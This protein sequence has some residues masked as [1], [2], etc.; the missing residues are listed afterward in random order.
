MAQ[1]TEGLVL[2][3]VNDVTFRTEFLNN[4]T[5]KQRVEASSL[6]ERFTR[7]TKERLAIVGKLY[8]SKKYQEV[9]NQ[10]KASLVIIRE[11]LESMNN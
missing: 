3:L 9:D 8:G 4:L 1:S 10:L 2:K 7:L 5:V 6:I 11:K